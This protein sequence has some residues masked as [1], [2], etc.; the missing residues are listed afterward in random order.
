[1]FRFSCVGQLFPIKFL[2][3]FFLPLNS[4]LFTRT[5]LSTIIIRREYTHTHTHAHAR[6]QKE[7]E[8]ERGGEGGE[9]NNMVVGI[10]PSSSF[11][12]MSVIGRVMLFS[13][14]S[15]LGFAMKSLELF[16][17][18]D[19]LVMLRFVVNVTLPALLLHTLSTSTSMYTPAQATKYLSNMPI[20]LCSMFVSFTAMGSA[21]YLY[22]KR[23]SNERGL[24]V[25]SMAGVNLGTYSYP[26]I[27]AIWGSEGLRLATLYDLPNSIFVFVISAVVFSYERS[28][29]RKSENI[30][31]RH[32]DGGMYSGEFITERIRKET[33]AKRSSVNVSDEDDVMTKDNGLSSIAKRKEQL[34]KDGP[35]MTFTTQLIKSGLGCYTYPSG[36]TYEGEWQQNVKNGLGVYK[37]AKGGSYVGNFKSGE[38]SGF[39]I[40]KL[41]SGVVKAGIWKANELEQIVPIEELTTTVRDATLCAEAARVKVESLK[42]ETLKKKALNMLKFPPFIAL[43]VVFV[44][45]II[46]HSLPTVVHKLAEPLANANNPLV[47]ITVGVLFEAGLRRQQTRDCVGFLAAKYATGL[48]CAAVVS[49]FIPHAFPIARGTLAA[50]CVMPVPSVVVQQAVKNNMDADLAASLVSGS[51]IASVVMLLFFAVTMN[52]ASRPFLFPFCLLILAGIVA[53]VGYFLDE[54]LSPN[55][56][57]TFK[58]AL[59]DKIHAV[60]DV[61]FKNN[62]KNEVEEDVLSNRNSES[63]NDSRGSSGGD[64]NDAADKNDKDERSSNNRGP[65]GPNAMGHV[66]TCKERGKNVWPKRFGVQTK[67]SLDSPR[68]TRTKKSSGNNA[69][70]SSSFSSSS[71]SMMSV[72]FASGTKKMESTIRRALQ[73]RTPGPFMAARRIVPSS[74]LFLY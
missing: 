5:A 33:Y 55:P 51:Q 26:F 50:L 6:T 29:T 66:S 20:V 44:S 38:F 8:R 10:E 16:S 58:G 35:K 15:F 28:K 41:R 19:G 70:S 62:N 31:L 56:H 57:T 63:R 65:S 32:D 1:M 22:Y 37:Y 14:Y 21:L 64:E 36:A 30:E 2:S 23:P 53:S 52:L 24:F 48:A 39:G 3:F 13:G 18:K 59:A 12:A 49:V 72:V 17:K 46:G 11:D 67:L 69:I 9:D 27:E 68:R 7:G 54:Y 43:A 71:S 61:I 47:L 60:L 45:K 73:T 34:E 42:Q 4:F 40:R 74:F 25:G